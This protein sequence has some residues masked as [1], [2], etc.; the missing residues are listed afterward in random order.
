MYQT[1]VKSV[2]MW[3]GLINI[4]QTSNSI[5]VLQAITEKSPDFFKNR[6]K[7]YLVDAKLDVDQ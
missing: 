7:V 4:G 1:K 5:S 3:H 6:G 2:A